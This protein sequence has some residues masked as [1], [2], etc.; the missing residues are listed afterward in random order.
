[1]ILIY[2]DREN[3]LNK[4]VLMLKGNFFW[5]PPGT[6]E[7][8]E[9]THTLKFDL[10]ED[11]KVHSIA[12]DTGKRNNITIHTTKDGVLKLNER[13][14]LKTLFASTKTEN[15]LWKYTSET[16]VDINGYD[17]TILKANFIFGCF[18]NRL[19]LP[20]VLVLL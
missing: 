4:N 1:M 6:Y 19:R 12:K 15:G 20:F 18:V 7:V 3:T 11:T 17:K 13:S 16:L 2:S 9:L 5:L 8:R 10:P 14:F